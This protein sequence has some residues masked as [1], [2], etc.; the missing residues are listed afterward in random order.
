[1]RR[2]VD[3]RSNGDRPDP[4]RGGH[5]EGHRGSGDRRQ[6]RDGLLVWVIVY[7][8]ALG[9]GSLGLDGHNL[10]D[11]LVMVNAITG[12]AEGMDLGASTEAHVSASSTQDADTKGGGNDG[13]SHL[14]CVQHRRRLERIRL[15]RDRE[16]RAR[17][18]SHRIQQPHAIAS[19]GQSDSS[20]R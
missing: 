9:L 3:E 17:W 16:H 2:A 11:Q 18:K 10:H 13:E 8:S 1:M 7:H 15:D 19:D 14:D 4:G 12:A 6:S 5:R 20:G